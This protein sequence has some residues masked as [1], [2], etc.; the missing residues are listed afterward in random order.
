MENKN[1]TIFINY[2]KDDSN[3]NAL[4][5]Y[6]ELQKYFSKEQL[7]KDFVDSINSA[8]QSCDVLLVLIGEEW[9]DMKDATGARRLDDPNDFVRLEI[10]KALERKIKVVP[11]LLDRTPMPKVGDLP[12]NLQALCRR[13]FVEIDPTRF[14]DDVRNLA[15]AIRTV[16]KS[17]GNPDAARK[18]P[19]EPPKQHQAPPP[20][21]QP[22]NPPHQQLADSQLIKPRKPENNLVWGILTTIF[23]CPP[24]GIF[25][26]IRANKVDSLYAE[27]KYV[28]AQAAADGAKKFAIWAAIIGGVSL[29]LYVLFVAAGGGGY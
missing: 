1:G 3:W 17:P 27:G 29:V 28:E 18:A 13:Q 8:L 22:Q 2:R 16:M 7:F 21:Q 26:I 24:L 23:C 25:S 11:V 6:Q 4:A 15:E 14:E 12:E 20:T 9:L 10:A 5:I 19:A